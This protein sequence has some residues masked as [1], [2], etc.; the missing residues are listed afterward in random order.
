MAVTTRGGLVTDLSR[1]DARVT[2]LEAGSS[3]AGGGVGDSTVLHQGDLDLIEHKISVLQG[4]V[5]NVA[6]YGAVLD[7]I[8]DDSSAVNDAVTAIPSTGGVLYF[9][10]G[11]LKGSITITGK[12]N[13]VVLG[14]GSASTIHNT[15][16]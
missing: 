8:T 2:A 4:L 10:R 11:K 3:G 6:D 13:L 15:T 16:A 14:A 1:L 9:P 5:F 7:G 12:D